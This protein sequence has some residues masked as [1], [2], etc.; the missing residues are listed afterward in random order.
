VTDA[1]R[2]LLVGMAE[3]LTLLLR[4]NERSRLAHAWEHEMTPSDRLALLI[5]NV[6][7]EGERT[8]Q[9]VRLSTWSTHVD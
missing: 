7:A 2:D 5:A 4:G 9:P 3:A 6:R 8:G 1:E